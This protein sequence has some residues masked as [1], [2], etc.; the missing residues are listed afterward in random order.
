[1]LLCLDVGDRQVLYRGLLEAGA[2]EA[3]SVDVVSQRKVR[4]EVF[5]H[6]RDRRRF[7]DRVQ[8]SVDLL[9]RSYP[10][11]FFISDASLLLT[12]TLANP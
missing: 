8:V 9:D 7:G 6:R 1:M 4:S 12:F 10:E 11:P 2:E 5:H 3:A